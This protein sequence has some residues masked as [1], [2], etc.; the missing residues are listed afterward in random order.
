M[1]SGLAILLFPDGRLPAN[2]LRWIAW[3]VIGMGA[4]WMLGAYLLAARAIV[5]HTVHVEA[6]GDLD[7]D[8]PSDG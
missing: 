1:L 8:R 3:A 7:G 5:E 4:V 2:R 6:S